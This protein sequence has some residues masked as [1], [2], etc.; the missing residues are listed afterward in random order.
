MPILL[1]RPQTLLRPHHTLATFF[2]ALRS[3]TF[4]T[5]FVTSY[6]YTVCLTRSI[7]LARIFP[8]IS[9]D[10]WDG[11]FGCVF[12]GCLVCGSSIWIENGRRRGEMALYVL[13]RAIRACLPDAWA[14]N[15]NRGVRIAERSVIYY[16][17]IKSSL[18]GLPRI[19]FVLSFSTLITAATHHPETLRGLSRWTLA[20]VTNGPN[21]GFWKRKRQNPSIP[22]TPSIPPTPT[23]LDTSKGSSSNTE[24]IP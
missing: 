23:I 1:T 17:T 5:T 10:F 20:F 2:G 21:A 14:R 4:L 18:K 6:W 13:P 24:T 16:T 15:G 11:P 3:A 8:F 12:A 9:H 22:S 19:A 7:A